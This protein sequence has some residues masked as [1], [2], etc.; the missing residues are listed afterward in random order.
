M[1]K[2]QDSQ[3][4]V[5]AGRTFKVQKHLTDFTV[6]RPKSSIQTHDLKIQPLSAVVTRCTAR[7]EAL[8]DQ[9][10]D[11]VREDQVCHHIYQLEDTKEE[12]LI[13]NHLCLRLHS[14]DPAWVERLAREKHLTIRSR[15]GD[16]YVMRVESGAKMN[17]LKLAWELHQLDEVSE[18]SPHRLMQLKACAPNPSQIQFFRSQWHLSSGITTAAHVDPTAGINVPQAWQMTSGDPNIVVSVMDDGF[19]LS[20]PAFRGVKLHPEARDFGSSTPMDDDQDPRPEMGDYH[21]TPVASLIFASGKSRDIAGVSPGC[22][23]LPIRVELGG[24]AGPLFMLDVFKYVSQRADVV[25]CSFGLA[26]SSMGLDPG[27]VQGMSQLTQTG[28]RRGT[29]LVIVFAAGNDDSPTRM[30]AT[31]NVN[32]VRYANAHTGKIV[33]IP[34]G[35]P[36]SAGFPTIPGV[37]VVGAMSSEKRKSGFSNWGPDITVV[38]PSNNGHYIQMFVPEGTPGRAN[39]VANYTGAGLFCANNRPGRG[40]QF[41]PLRDRFNTLIREDFYTDQFGGTSGAAPIVAGVVG[42]M[43]SVNPNLSASEVKGILMQTA[44]R[45]LDPTLDLLQ[46]PNMQGK[47]DAGGFQ[48]GRSPFFGSG[49]VDA[50]KAVQQAQALAG[51]LPSMMAAMAPPV[52]MAP[53]QDQQLFMMPWNQLWPHPESPN[54]LAGQLDDVML[55][56]ASAWMVDANGQ[57]MGHLTP[58]AQ[59]MNPGEYLLEPGEDAQFVARLPR[60]WTRLTLI[61]PVGQNP[62]WLV[63]V[64]DV[65]KRT[66]P[67]SIPHKPAN[68]KRELVTH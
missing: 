3:Q 66:P 39:F 20:H 31:A 21:G 65:A 59:P 54:L 15:M 8:R 17:P 30:S 63:I 43:L 49:K 55:S 28:G 38:A 45:Q 44:D 14:D 36:V 50:F 25:N 26:P 60:V 4:L 13:D 2:N 29:G 61:P 19:D 11:R 33:T 32:G 1:A 5:V 67:R 34:K 37:I 62:S 58:V 53:G 7:T 18:C 16:T 42:L 52:S 47:H 51:P 68:G 10:M 35:N 56:S 22:T 48:N 12:V 6:V 27:Y 64:A 41:S 24:W 46:D 9:F 23:F 57:V 40:D